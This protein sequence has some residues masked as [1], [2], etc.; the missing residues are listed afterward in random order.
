M[1]SIKIVT[2]CLVGLLFIFLSF[3]VFNPKEVLASSAQP[4]LVTTSVDPWWNDFILFNGYVYFTGTNNHSSSGLGLYKT[5]G[6]ASGTTLV[7]SVVPRCMVVYGNKLYIDNGTLWESDGT[8]A[9]TV[10]VSS[11]YTLTSCPVVMG[12]LM[13]FGGSN[14]STSALWSFDGTTFVNVDTIKVGSYITVMN[15]DLYFEGYVGGIYSLYKSDGTSAGTVNV[16]SLV[17]PEGPSSIGYTSQFIVFNNDLYFEGFGPDGLN[18]LWKTDGTQAGTIEVSTVDPFDN[19]A[20]LNNTLYF[21]GN[22]PSNNNDNLWKTDGTQAGTVQVTSSI[23]SNYIMSSGSLLYFEGIGPGNVYSLYSSDGTNAGTAIVSSIF[24]SSGLTDINNIL[25]FE[26]Y[27]GGS[28]LYTMS[29]SI[30][31]PTPVISSG[32]SPNAFVSTT[33]SYKPCTNPAPSSQPD[34]FQIDTSNHNAT[35]YFVPAHSPVTGYIIYYGVA[36]MP[37]TYSAVLSTNEQLGVIKYTI[38]YLASQSNYTFKIEPL[39]GCTT[40]PLS[41]SMEAK[42]T[43]STSKSLLPFYAL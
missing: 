15:S 35:L 31:T 29:L 13:Y 34:L 27:S 6:T 1:R 16:D 26:G 38:N 21:D 8:N 3:I 2:F 19:F 30:A 41:R 37:M 20:I 22:N 25:Y 32:S 43:L 28:S 40:G 9:G 5:D 7:N 11:L 36:S 39:N 42:T 14:G 33:S 10:Q 18:A 17:D 24:P 12:S 4:Q 23:A